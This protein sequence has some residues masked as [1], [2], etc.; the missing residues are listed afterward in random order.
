M[1][2][3]NRALLDTC[4]VC[5]KE[6]IDLFP[7]SAHCK[8][9]TGWRG[10]QGA[11]VLCFCFKLDTNS[12]HIWF[13][14][15]SNRRNRPTRCPIINPRSTWQR[16]IHQE[17]FPQVPWSPDQLLAIVLYFILWITFSMYERPVRSTR[18]ICERERETETE[19]DRERDRD[20]ERQRETDRERQSERDRERER[21]TQERERVS[22][23][24]FV[25]EDHLQ[26]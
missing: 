3:D 26:R 4:V 6:S 19:R 13:L 22:Y 20:R 5:E 16:Q 24:V 17:D 7:Y 23:L 18:K 12:F 9:G 10:R 8:E 1:C 21:Q 2:E 14:H 11:L 15:H 25:S